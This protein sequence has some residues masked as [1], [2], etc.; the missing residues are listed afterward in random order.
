MVNHTLTVTEWGVEHTL[1]TSVQ[2]ELTSRAFSL[3]FLAVEP[4]GDNTVE[5]TV[6]ADV[7]G[8]MDIVEYQSAVSLT[9]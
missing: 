6:T 7:T 5:L 3:E 8:P 1:H 4:V 9:K 2:L